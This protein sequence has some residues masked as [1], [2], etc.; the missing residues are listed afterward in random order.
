MGREKEGEREK[1]R[2]GKGGREGEREGGRRREIRRGR[3]RERDIG[4]EEGDDSQSGICT[5]NLKGEEKKNPEVVI[6]KPQ[7]QRKQ[8]LRHTK[9][10][11]VRAKFINYEA[12]MKI[13]E[14]PEVCT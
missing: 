12:E 6:T 3:E 1:D 14:L 9:T 11:S 4:G 8:G 10:D 2:E 5:S 13:K 7:M